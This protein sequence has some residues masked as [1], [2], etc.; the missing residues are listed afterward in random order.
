MR[1]DGNFYALY[2]YGSRVYGTN[3][4]FSDWDYVGV[5]PG[6]GFSELE[7]GAIDVKLMD[8]E[9]FQKLVNDHNVSALECLFLPEEMVLVKPERPWS[10]N[11]DLSMLRRSF[12]QKSNQ[13]FGKAKKKFVAPYDWAVDEIKRG[14]KSLFH[15]LRILDFGIQIAQFGEIVCY[16]TCNYMY[17]EIME[18][19]SLIWEDYQN[20]WQPEYNRMCTEFRKLAPK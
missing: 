4:E 2:L 10:F 1:P 8:L 19:E 17:D 6:V 13:S 15:S 18:N 12:S 7:R 9:H 5:Q 11:L 3:T 20:R 14:K 16:D